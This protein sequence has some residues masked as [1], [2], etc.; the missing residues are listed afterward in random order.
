MAGLFFVLRVLAT[1]WCLSRLAAASV[2][3]TKP[4]AI[5][6]YQAGAPAEVRW[7][8]DNKKPLL[9]STGVMQIDLYEGNSVSCAPADKSIVKNYASNWTF[10]LLSLKN[11]HGR[12][13]H[14]WQPSQ[15]T[16]TRSRCPR[17]STSQHRSFQKIITRCELCLVFYVLRLRT[18]FLIVLYTS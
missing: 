8:E 18:A 7:I 12:V 9:N 10:L 6:I 16:W 2:Y 15:R 13:R 4:T 5:T 17:R 11:L 14:I 1:F 3:P